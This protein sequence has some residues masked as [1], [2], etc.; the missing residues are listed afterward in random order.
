[1]AS[2]LK[3]VQELWD[4]LSGFPCKIG[5]T[6]YL[7]R[8][9]SGHVLECKLISFSVGKVPQVEVEWLKSYHY[10]YKINLEDNTVHAIDAT[11]RHKTEMK[12]WYECF[13]PQRKQLIKLCEDNA[14]KEKKRKK[15][16]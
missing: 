1:M 10:Q 15:R 3:E 2:T 9:I 12:L 13:E 14:L 7:V 5:S 6:V 16:L 4:F 11:A 8:K